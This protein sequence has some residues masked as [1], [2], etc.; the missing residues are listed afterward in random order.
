MQSHK[1]RCPSCRGSA[2]YLLGCSMS[3]RVQVPNSHELAYTWTSVT[4]K[5][6]FPSIDCLDSSRK[7]DAQSMLQETATKHDEN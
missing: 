1:I 5:T 4:T 7:P 3:L 2:H 6:Q